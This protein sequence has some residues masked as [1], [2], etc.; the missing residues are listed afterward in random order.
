MTD[1]ERA[2]I[3]ALWIAIKQVNQ[4]QLTLQRNVERL[5]FRLMLQE[6]ATVAAEM[7][8]PRISH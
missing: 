3:A 8:Q 2:E 6:A 5:S 1:E 4:N 7:D